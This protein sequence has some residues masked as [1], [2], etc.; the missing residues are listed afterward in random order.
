[1]MKKRNYILI[2]FLTS[3][4]F[5]CKTQKKNDYLNSKEESEFNTE[6]YSENGVCPFEGCTYGEWSTLDRVKVFKKPHL[7]SE[8]V[9][10]IPPNK[11]FT[12]KDGK[13]EIKPGIAYKIKDL[14]SIG[15]T[16]DETTEILYDK[17]IYILH[18]V[19]EGYSKVY[20]NGKYNYLTSTPDNDSIYNLY[21]PHFDW[22]KFEKYPTEFKWWVEIEFKEFKGWILMS[23]K[24]KPIDRF[25]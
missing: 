14:P 22:L 1:M 6:F 8:L 5:S 10:Q 2:F 23:E 18:Y 7:E 20:Q 25:G 24:V 9:G 3:I 11:K 12:A 13:I 4:S 21:K 19:G 17:P 16:E 15:Y